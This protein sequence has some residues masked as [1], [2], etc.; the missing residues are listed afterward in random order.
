MK[1]LIDG[2][3]CSVISITERIAKEFGVPCHIYCNT[4]T[5]IQSRYSDIHTMDKS[6]NAA[7]FAIVNACCEH[8]IVITND[9]GLAAMVLSKRAIPV[10]SSGV[11]YTDQNIDMFLNSRYVNFDRR[12]K[13]G[14]KQIKGQLYDRSFKQPEEQFISL[15]RKECAAVYA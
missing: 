5:K 4:T 7:D 2:D 10:T 12:R 6:C 11:R 9:S 3:G 15:L 14:R 8:D 13:T 1:I